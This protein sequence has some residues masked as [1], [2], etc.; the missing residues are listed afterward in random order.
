MEIIFGLVLVFL[1]IRDRINSQ[2]FKSLSAALRELRQEILK[3][4]AER[5]AQIA[6][7]APAH[8]AMP[9]SARADVPSRASAAA[10]AQAPVPPKS[11]PAG[12]AAP[13]PALETIAP[14]PPL[15][16]QQAPAA[17]WDEEVVA[18][19]DEEVFAP[20]A[21]ASAPPSPPPRRWMPP[22]PPEST[23]VTAIK[24][25][26]FSGNLVAKLGLLILF[27][28]VSFLLKYAAERV[29]VPI[30]LR[31]SG[32]VIADIA[33][34][35]WGWRIRNTRRIIS[36]PVQGAALAILMLVT[37]GAF[38]L[39]HLFPSG[40]A[41]ALLFVLTV[42][43][44]LL[45]V[46]QDAVWLAVFGI[47]G[48]FLAPVMTSTGQGSH[49]ALFSYYTLLNAGIG[50]IAFK[51]NWRMLNLLGFAFTFAIGTAWG[52]LKYGPEHYLSTQLF[53]ILFAV[54]FNALALV[55]A[56]RQN[57]DGFGR[58]DAVLVFGTPLLG[59]GL[60]V[61]LV[62]DMHFGLAYSAL[63]AGLAYVG[64]ASTLW[65]R[66]GQ[67]FQMLSRSYLALALVFGTLTIPFALDGRWISAAWALEGAAL[68]WFGL[69]Q[70]N[71]LVCLF[72]LL[73]Q[74]G[75][76]LTFTGTAGSMTNQMALNAYLWRDFLLL[77][78]SSLFLARTIRRRS[79]DLPAPMPA[80]LASMFLVCAALWFMAGAWTEILL[81]LNGANLVNM[82]AG[83]ALVGSVL[84]AFIARRMEW[85]LAHRL[86]MSV[87]YVT[88]A[89]L[90]I[91]YIQDLMQQSSGSPNLLETPIIGALIMFGGAFVSGRVLAKDDT[92]NLK[93]FSGLVLAWSG[94]WW[95]GAVIQVF[96]RWLETNWPGA[97]SHQFQYYLICVAISGIAFAAL[98]RKISWPMARWLSAPVWA[99]LIV[100]L[101]GLGLELYGNAMP[102]ALS[103]IALL[104]LLAG[105]EWLMHTWDATDSQLSRMALKG[106]HTVRT[107]GVWIL[108]WPTLSILVER[109]L[110]TGTAGEKALLSEAGYATSV[111]W[112]ILLPAWL[113]IG[114]AIW[115]SA[116]ARRER[117]PAAPF[118]AWYSSVLVPLGAAWSLLL[119]LYW[120]VLYDGS[121]A[122]LPYLPVFNPIDLTTAFALLF[123][124][125]AW[126]GARDL[127]MPLLPADSM[128]R[129][130]YLLG[131][132]AY[133]WLNMMLLRTAS[134]MLGIPYRV[135]LLFESQAVQAM[136]SLTWSITA[137]VLMLRAK[138][139][140]SRP[141]WILGAAFLGLV[142]AKLFLIDLQNAGSVARIISFVGVGLLMLAI[143]YLAPYP[144]K[145]DEVP[146]SMN[147]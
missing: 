116:Q 140:A 11:E 130:P 53:L 4:Q 94:F 82:L 77:S 92:G 64:M 131:G 2:R 62:S 30:E 45:A 124:T 84:L 35:V 110:G 108:V 12:G 40:F 136:L 10:A 61:S 120:N 145:Q 29:T 79:A 78:A 118:G 138:R 143:G 57:E 9:A 51:R 123:A 59:F 22:P 50:A 128:A 58:V 74:L 107:A 125:I 96:S 36:L 37:F 48:G 32:I 132:I 75:A 33:L 146:A 16:P 115:V 71:A 28:G 60:Q 5:A 91:L 8:A 144:I 121:M 117:W 119:T 47:C 106:L 41:F 56:A 46:M 43:T 80:W 126:R 88:S 129:A 135:D 54:F 141:V 13:E 17:R 93:Q 89:L 86:A 100:S 26:L 134:H 76:W 31:L 24:G 23:L 38:R 69:R 97:V 113:M 95:Y 15:T 42:F 68:I 127:A 72:G 73:V 139:S 142:M 133:L 14:V 147:A 63:A 101:L 90:A 7:T 18:H 105:G 39:Y 137:M 25:W 67:Q 109:W 111:S 6:G 20:A 99:G 122:P 104:A 44:C 19:L 70:P 87:Q 3:L 114:T 112:S 34:L 21:A 83:S 1:F 27:I 102:G 49:I 103:W 98:A 81:R 65:R 85:Q 52:V 66:A 55:Y